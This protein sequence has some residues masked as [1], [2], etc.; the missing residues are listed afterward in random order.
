MARRTIDEQL[1]A[2]RKKLEEQKAKVARLQGKKRERQRKTDT[3]RKVL[4]GALLLERIETDDR[5]RMW[6]EAQI[7]EFLTRDSDRKVF[8]LE[9]KPPATDE[10]DATLEY[11]KD[12]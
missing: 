6:F 2:E 11:A 9:P 4:A 12:P 1:E 8:G 10:L 3:R 5:L 7:D